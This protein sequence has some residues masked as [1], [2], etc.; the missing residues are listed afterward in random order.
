MH[1]QEQL[2]DDWALGEEC[3]AVNDRVW[4]EDHDGVRV[5]C[6]G[7]TPFYTYDRTD[8]VQHLFCACQ[9]IEAKLAKQ[10]EVVRAFGIWPRI[11][12]GTS[13]LRKK[14]YLPAMDHHYVSLFMRGHIPAC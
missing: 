11:S 8:R 4:F 5:V 6:V 7:N 13:W 14:L 3:V 1:T 9:F 12:H 2:A 10:C